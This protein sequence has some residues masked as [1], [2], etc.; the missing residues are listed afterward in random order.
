MKGL[1]LAAG[2]GKRLQPLTLATPKPL[3]KVSGQALIDHTLSRCVRNGI[4]EVLVVSGHLGNVLTDHL[5]ERKADPVVEVVHNER[6]DEVN[7]IYSV[8]LARRVLRGRAFVLINGDV[9]F[10]NAILANLLHCPGSIV[11]AVDTRS[12]LG[13]EEMK[14]VTDKQGRI[15]GIGKDLRAFKGHGEYIGLS[16]FEPAGSRHFF[17]SVESVL[18]SAGPGHYYEAAFQHLINEDIEIRA[19]DVLG[20]PWIE[21]D[22]HEDLEAAQTLA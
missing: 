4:G 14:V 10:S 5:T 11:L 21:I 2:S 16:K 15:K 20:Q 18:Q 7:N 8:H 13:H 12:S 22:F 9:L 3:L 19:L 1:I 17:D 6:F